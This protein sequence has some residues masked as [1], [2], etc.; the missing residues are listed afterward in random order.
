M[1]NTLPASFIGSISEGTMRTEDLLPRFL[2]VLAQAEPEHSA[3]V[4]MRNVYAAATTLS[5]SE[6]HISPDDVL[7]LVGFWD[8]EHT[9]YLLNEDVF[10]ALN[11]VAPEGT[12]FGSSEG[13]GASYG[14]WYSDCS[15]CGHSSEDHTRSDN[16]ERCSECDCGEYDADE[17]D[18]P[19]FGEQA[20]ITL[21]DAEPDHESLLSEGYIDSINQALRGETTSPAKL[22]YGSVL[23]ERPC[24]NCDTVDVHFQGKCNSG[25][26]MHP[27]CLAKGMRYTSQYNHYLF[28]PTDHAW[29]PGTYEA[30]LI[31]ERSV[32]FEAIVDTKVLRPIK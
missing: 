27:D 12:Y 4:E 9:S 22:T 32:A 25:R 17:G 2:N 8:S 18:D 31:T 30:Q 13:D 1:S 7:D 29:I 10:N 24:I 6:G 11:E 15:D 16:G 23:I 3:V 28:T 14:F 26:C 5:E 21:A 19:D 20:D